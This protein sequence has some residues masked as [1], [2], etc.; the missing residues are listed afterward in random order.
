M[1]SGTLIN[2]KGMLYVL[3][4]PNAKWDYGLKPILGYHLN[5]KNSSLSST[6]MF[7]GGVKPCGMIANTCPGEIKTD[8]LEFGNNFVGT[9]MIMD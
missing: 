7:E 2:L 1:I 4:Y 6:I 9:T 5:I 3:A 8:I